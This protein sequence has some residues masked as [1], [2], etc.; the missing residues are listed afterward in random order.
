[1]GKR[2]KCVRA[3]VQWDRGV[4]W[5]PAANLAG[6]RHK[7]TRVKRSARDSDPFQMLAAAVMV[8][9]K[10]RHFHFIGKRLRRKRKACEHYGVTSR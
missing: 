2:V 6:A 1:M 10:R 5:N 3:Q 9:D 8:G 4:F 7:Y